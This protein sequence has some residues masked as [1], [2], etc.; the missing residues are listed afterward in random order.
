M[1]RSLKSGELARL[2]GV[3][4]DTVRY[5]ERIGLLQRPA[6]TP[7]GYRQYPPNSVERMQVIRQALAVG[8]SLSELAALLQVRDR[9]GTPCR[10][11]RALA[12]RKLQQTE[13]ELR[14]LQAYR[15]RLRALLKQWDRRLA[16]MRPGQRA[17]LLESLADPR[18]TRLNPK[19]RKNESWQHRTA[20]YSPGSPSASPRADRARVPDGL[21]AS[22]R[23]QSAR[24]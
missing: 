2:A 7:S 9:G 21:G 20:R 19:E 15:R 10:D 17:G 16:R 4:T 14:E 3:S 13:R 1:Q 6:R 12:G 23:G 8:F 24:R 22:G 11:V 5:Y 18:S